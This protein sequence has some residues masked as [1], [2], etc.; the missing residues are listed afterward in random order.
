MST[1][2]VK[3]VWPGEKVE[4]L[5]ELRNSHGS[6][7]VIWNAVGK[8][9]LGFADFEYSLR[10]NEIWPLYKR[11]DMPEHH[12]AILLMT[13]DNAIVMKADY[14]RAAADIRA[15]LADFPPKD[16]YASHWPRIAEI[17]DGEPECPAVGFRMTSVSEDP[18]EGPWNDETEEYDAPDWSLYWDAYA[19]A[20]KWPAHNVNSATPPNK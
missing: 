5:E 16:G 19:E 11:A 18:F 13:Y 3:A 10:T 4:D 12:R 9:Y 15:F 17:F 14:K 7:P 20:A 6:A 8:R 2:T 1:T